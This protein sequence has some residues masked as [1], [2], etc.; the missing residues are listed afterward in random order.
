MRI[1]TWGP[2]SVRHKGCWLYHWKTDL[3]VLLNCC[4]DYSN[5]ISFN[6]KVKEGQRKGIHYLSFAISKKLKIWQFH[7]V[8]GQDRKEMSRKA[9][10][11][12]RMSFC[13]LSLEFSCV[14][15]T[16]HPKANFP[17]FAN[18]KTRLPSSVLN[19]NCILFMSLNIP[20]N[21]KASASVP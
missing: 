6:L 12:G 20:P 19:L 7:I 8:V 15:T 9:W 11:K 21:G 4:T 1:L 2:D 13:S 14:Q 16:T 17:L 10:S 18:L 3:Y 5:S